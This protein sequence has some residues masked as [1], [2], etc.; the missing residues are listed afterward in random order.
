MGHQLPTALWPELCPFGQQPIDIGFA[1]GVMLR[2]RQVIRASGWTVKYL[3][4]LVA[5]NLVHPVP[6]RRGPRG[7]RRY[8]YRAAEI[9]KRIGITPAELLTRI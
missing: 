5:S 7:N 4:K 1:S 6:G 2:R 9:A 8:Y 3:R